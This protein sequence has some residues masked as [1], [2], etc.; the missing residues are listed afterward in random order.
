MEVMNQKRQHDEEERKE[1]DAMIKMTAELSIKEAKET[2]EEET[3]LQD[4][5]E[6]RLTR[7]D[8]QQYNVYCEKGKTLLSQK[9]YRKALNYFE[10]AYA[11]YQEDRA[12]KRKIQKLQVGEKHSIEKDDF[13]NDLRNAWRK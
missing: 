3:R 5:P 12:L 7:D 10:K 8:K 6:K 11:I 2:Q 9:R 4:D 13:S 1:W